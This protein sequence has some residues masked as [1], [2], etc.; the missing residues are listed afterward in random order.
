MQAR[1]SAYSQYSR[2][3][4]FTKILFILKKKF[5]NIVAVLFS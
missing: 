5:L 4:N 2:S 1:E 3:N